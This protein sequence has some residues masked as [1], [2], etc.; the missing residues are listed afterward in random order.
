MRIT[1]LERVNDA[2]STFLENYPFSW[3]TKLIDNLKGNSK[4][5]KLGHRGV[6]LIIMV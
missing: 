1:L 5:V 3:E 2:Y 4:G 6:L